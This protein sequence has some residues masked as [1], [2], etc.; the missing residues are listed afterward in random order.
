MAC[1]TWTLVYPWVLNVILSRLDSS[2]ISAL[3]GMLSTVLQSNLKPE[4]L[5][6]SCQQT[7]RQTHTHTHTHSNKQ[8]YYYIKI[9]CD[10]TSNRKYIKEVHKWSTSVYRGLLP[11]ATGAGYTEHEHSKLWCIKWAMRG[12]YNP[13]IVDEAAFFRRVKAIPLQLSQYF[14]ISALSCRYAS[15][16]TSRTHCSVN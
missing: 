2:R 5:S 8:R 9:R 16:R 12:I 4:G 11:G 3:S 13:W 7:D 1:H 6:S 10:V 15:C 14:Q